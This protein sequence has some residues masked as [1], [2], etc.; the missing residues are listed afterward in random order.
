MAIEE[1]DVIAW[2]EA[3][4]PRY[5]CPQKVNFVDELPEGIG[6]KVLRRILR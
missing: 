2:V 1:D 5:K 4:L 3:R 6:G